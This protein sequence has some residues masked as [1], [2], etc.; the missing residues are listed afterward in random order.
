M[1]FKEGEKKS[2][3]Q[4]ILLLG[5]C[6]ALIIGTTAGPM[7]SRFYFLHGGHRV[8]MSA[9]LET[10]GWPL[11]ILPIWIS[12]TRTKSTSKSH[13]TPRLFLASIL[14]GVLTGVDDFLYAWGLGFLPISTSALLIA[15]QL[16][17]NAVFAFFL[18]RQKF[19]PYSINAVI[20][21]TLGSVML[22]FNTESDRPKGVTNLEYWI[23]FVMTIIAAA[24]YG[25]IL[26]LIELT[27]KKTSRKIT[28]LLVMEMQ[29]IMSF[30]A[31]VVCTIG[32][33]INKDFAA[34][35]RE[36][37][38]S[39][40][41]EFKF[42]MVLVWCAICW[43]LFYIG[44]FGVVFLTSSLLSG[45]IIAVFIPVNE[46]LGV[47]LY[48]EKF[49]AEK[50]MALVMSLWGFASYLYGERTTS[51]KARESLESARQGEERV[52]DLDIDHQS[53]QT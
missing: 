35:G 53:H 17:F 46:V 42:Y 41:G 5:N 20:L 23:G 29:F 1:D 47:L 24:L 43:Q 32:M 48:G 38:A 25:F 36:A 4:W 14:L 2:L 15:S 37:K 22:A 18:V 30:A 50:G 9:W 51:K 31:T 7:T 3:G 27:Y 13:V 44:I 33:A 8:W 39:D 19:T 49:N 6:L 10:G 26:P 28:Y 21:L 16:G 45:V 52:S 11:L 12:Y 34:V 40:V